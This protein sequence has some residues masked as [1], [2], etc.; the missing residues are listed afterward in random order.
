VPVNSGFPI[1]GGPIASNKSTSVPSG[2]PAPHS[3][4]FELFLPGQGPG[5]FTQFWPH[6][7]STQLGGKAAVSLLTV[8]VLNS[9]AGS[10]LVSLL[11]V[12]VLSATQAIT[13]VSGQGK[14]AGQSSGKAAT[15]RTVPARG[16]AQA[17]GQA[18]LNS[19]STPLAGF[20][21]GAAMAFSSALAGITSGKSALGKAMALGRAGYVVWSIFSAQGTGM[22][23]GKAASAIVGP[24]VRSAQGEGFGKSSANYRLSNP[25]ARVSQE[26]EEWLAAA[27]P[28]ARSSQVVLEFLA[29]ADSN[30]R[31][32]QQVEEWGAFASPNARVS[33]QTEE[34]LAN[35]NNNA[36]VGQIVLEWLILNHKV[37][38][39][40]IYPDE[41]RLPGLGYS[42]K[43]TL[44]YFNSS[45]QVHTSGRRVRVSYAQFP[46]W[47]IELLYNALRDKP[48]QQEYKIFLG[49]FGKMAGT[50]NGFCIRDNDDC[51]VESQ[52]FVTT[53]GLNS[54]FGPLFR[55]F[56]AEE[57]T[58]DE[59][60]GFIDLTK[61]FRVYVDDEL[62]S[63]GDP[64]WGYTVQTT[65]PVNQLLKFNNTPEAGHVI[66]LDFSF[67]FYVQFQE[68]S[69]NVE[70]FLHQIYKAGSVTFQS[71][72]G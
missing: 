59:P 18:L 63:A 27:D 49:F 26:V 71:L 69:M 60:V 43:K 6:H 65:Q 45:P 16:T 4:K 22:A 33:Q 24:T 68:D 11:T 35:A 14:G 42:V 52:S 32:S 72:R 48:S 34:W 62:V 31:I 39:P 29:T 30:A 41:T 51:E 40:A 2:A 66:T 9:V 47:N 12:E 56:G 23:K 20:A 21:S 36:R 67:Y 38:M 19:G 53:D 37:P 10:V 25:N 17:K 28:N 64:T 61:P 50:L 1:G 3:L 70:K 5:P 15:S 44:Q 55:T 58:F 57:N 13:A 54:Q 8:E 7:Y 46:L